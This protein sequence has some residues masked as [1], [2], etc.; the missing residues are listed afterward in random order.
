VAAG[1]GCWVEAQAGVFDAVGLARLLRLQWPVLQPA[2]DTDPETQRVHWDLLRRTSPARRLQL[3]LSLSRTIM[4]LS[5]A[6]LARQMPGAGSEAIGLRF[7]A[8]HYGEALAEAVRR[9]IEARP[10]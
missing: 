7:V 6:G 1:S 4:A 3:A 8:L 5:R 9:D 10:R 2:L